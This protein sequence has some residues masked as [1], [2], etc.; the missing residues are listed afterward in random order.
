MDASGW[1]LQA[2][3]VTSIGHLTHNSLLIMELIGFSQDIWKQ[4]FHLNVTVVYLTR[5]HWGWNSPPP[6]QTE[7]GCHRHR[8]AEQ[9]LS[10]WTFLTLSL[11]LPHPCGEHTSFLWKEGGACCLEQSACDVTGFFFSMLT[12]QPASAAALETWDWMLSLGQI[13]FSLIV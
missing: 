6:P 2:S 1:V 3:A 12:I 8:R 7:A 11:N 9:E 13:L 5:E 4:H 10:V